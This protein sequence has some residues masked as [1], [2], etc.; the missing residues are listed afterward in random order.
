M[1]V[2][3][4]TA[5]ECAD[6]ICEFL[7]TLNI[8]AFPGSD[9]DL[10]AV[11]PSSSCNVLRAETN[12]CVKF[13]V[14]LFSD[15]GT[16]VVEV[17]RTAGCSYRFRE[18]SRAL[19]RSA[20]GLSQTPPKTQLAIP[21]AL[22]QVSVE[23]QYASIQDDFEITLNLLKSERIDSQALAL[24]SLE[25]ITKSCYAIDVAAKFVLG[26][27]CL[28]LLMS[29][30]EQETFDDDASSVSRKV[31]GILANALS[32]LSTVDLAEHL[33]CCE[34][35]KESSF[36]SVLLSTLKEASERPHDAYHAARCLSVLLVSNDV[37]NY[38]MDM[39]CVEV[40]ETACFAGC[41]SHLALER[42]SQKLLSQL[43]C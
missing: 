25:N 43:R 23:A 19:L 37:K 3:D 8:A 5:Q 36:L 30:L 6:R 22:P 35:L 14:R 4:S 18:T 27:N 15:C 12:D 10:G 39:S 26:S 11:E 41:K 38:V 20:K 2:N 42:E 13:A 34:Y 31:L 17:Q 40:V 29:L 28:S 9:D 32:A 1:H 7:R 16:I 33:A 21:V 24:E